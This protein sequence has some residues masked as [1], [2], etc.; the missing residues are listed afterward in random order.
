MVTG[1]NKMTVRDNLPLYGMKKFKAITV[2]QILQLQDSPIAE[3]L[4]PERKTNHKFS[5]PKKLRDRLKKMVHYGMVKQIGIPVNAI[6]GSDKNAYCLT[7]R[8]VD[9]LISAGLLSD[10]EIEFACTVP[11]A[12]SL[13]H[14]LCI[15][16]ILLNM[17]IRASEIGVTTDF[18]PDWK[19][20]RGREIVPI[21]DA[22][23]CFT[24]KNKAML[25]LEMDI[26]KMTL[27]V[28][29]EKF[30]AYS[31]YFQC[32]GFKE[33]EQ[34]FGGASFKGFRVLFV[35]AKS[36]RRQDNILQICQANNYPFVLLTTLQEFRANGSFAQIWKSSGTLAANTISL[37]PKPKR[38]KSQNGKVRPEKNK[39]KR[40][41]K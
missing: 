28:I 30:Y 22:V 34:C 29:E 19:L 37:L 9:H 35:T 3:K 21:P 20:P 4:F 27:P 18:I 26:G 5:S 2:K 13:P 17:D 39:K 16:D 1:Q 6:T 7:K 25:F 12:N 38:K 14:H 24:A 36:R 15:V 8:G 40:K 32:G 23:I 31:Q 33:Y 41:A 11:D 10:D